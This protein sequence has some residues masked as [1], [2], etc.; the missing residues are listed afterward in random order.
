MVADRAGARVSSGVTPCCI[1]RH[2]LLLVLLL[3]AP[4]ALAAIPDLTN[5]GTRTEWGDINLGPTGMRGWMYHDNGDTTDSRQILVTSVEAGSPAAGI[6][7]ANDVILGVSGTGAAPTPFTADTCKTLGNAITNAEARNP[8]T[9]KFLRWRAG[10]TDTVQ[11][12]LQYFGAYSAT[13]PYNC[14]KSAAILEMGLQ[15]MMAT[16][17]CGQYSFGT[18]ALLAADDPS[19]PNNAARQ[20]RA[21]NEAIASIPNEGA[22]WS[23]S[24]PTVRPDW[25]KPWYAGHA[26]IVLCEYYLKTH[27]PAVLPG[28]NGFVHVIERGQSTFGSM[29]HFWAN[30]WPDGSPNGPMTGY[31]SVN[32]AAVPALLGLQ[33]AKKCGCTDPRLDI[34]IERASSFFASYVGKGVIPYG[35]HMP[36][37]SHSANGKSG[38]AAL[39]FEMQPQRTAARDYFAKIATAAASE[40]LGG[41]TGYW[42]NALWSPLGAAVGGEEAA[43]SHF[44]R[45]IWMFDLCRTWDGRFSYD[46]LPD[47]RAGYRSNWSGFNMSTAILLTYALPYRNLQI[48]GKGRA[49]AGCMSHEDVVKADLADIDYYDPTTRSTSQLIEDL[50]SFSCVVRPG[51][52]AELAGRTGERAQILAT[53]VSMVPNPNNPSRAGACDALARMGDPASASLLVAQLDDPDENVRYSATAALRWFSRDVLFP[54]I[55]EILAVAG[56][57]ARPSM[58]LD[59]ENPARL[60]D[61]ELASL[62]FQNILTDTSTLHSIDRNYLYPAIRMAALHP[63]GNVNRTMLSIYPMLSREDCLALA[64][65]LVDSVHHQSPGDRM[66]DRYVRKAGLDAMQSYNFAE[67]VPLAEMVVDPSDGIDVLRRYAGS[68]TLVEPDPRTIEFLIESYWWRSD[69]SW[70]ALDAINA[71]VADTNP[72]APT[73][74]KSIQSVT[75]DAPTLTLPANWTTLRVKAYDYAKGDSRFTWRKVHGKGEV[76]FAPNGTAGSKN[77]IALFDGTPGQYLFE[78]TMSDSRGFTEVRQTVAVTLRNSNGTLPSNSPPSALAQTLTVGTATPTPIT[79]TGSDPENLALNYQITTPPAHGALTGTA[80]YLVYTSDHNYTGSDTFTFQVMDSEGQVATANINLTVGTAAPTELAVYEPFDYPAGALNGKSGTSEVGFAGPW[81]ASTG[82]TISDG[83]LTYGPL[84]TKGGKAAGA[85]IGSRVISPSALADKGLLADGATLWMSAV[86]G[87]GPGIDRSYLCLFLANSSFSSAGSTWDQWQQWIQNEGAQ[88]GAGIGITLGYTNRDGSV[89]AAFVGN[90]ANCLWPDRFYFDHSG[91]IWDNI[92]TGGSRLVVAK[93]TWGATPQDDDRI[94]VYEPYTDLRLPDQPI[95]S[96][97]GKVD[98]STFD[99]LTFFGAATPVLD[100]IR[101]GADYRSVLMGSVPA[102]DAAAPVPNPIAFHSAPAPAGPTSIRMVASTAFDPSGVEYFFTCAAGGGHD[103]GWQ[104]SPEYT[105]TGLNPG[106]SYSYTVKA[107]D[108]SV[109]HNQTAPS[110]AA[111]ITLPVN[112]QVPVVLGFSQAEA[113]ALITSRGLVVGT[114]TTTAS[115]S[116]DQGDVAQ[117]NPVGGTSAALGAAVNLVVAE[118]VLLATVPNLTGQTQSAANTALAAQNLLVGTV[119][120]DYSET[121]PAGQI[122]STNPV[123]GSEINP[124]STVDLVVSAGSRS[125]LLPLSKLFFEDFESPTTPTAYAQG[126]LPDNGK[127][128]GSWVDYGSTWHGM[129]DKAGGDFSAP[130]PNYQAYALR[131]ANT[132]ITTA[133]GVVGTLTFNT[134]YTV[135]FDVVRDNFNAG[136]TYE[137]ELVAFNPGDDRRNATSKRPGTVLASTHGYAFSDGS[138]ARISFDFTALASSPHLGK[139]VA[140]RF[141]APWTQTNALIDNVSI[142]AVGV[143]LADTVPPLLVATSPQDEATGVDTHHVLTMTFNE[144]VT[145][146]AGGFTLR[147]VT[148]GTQQFLNPSDPSGVTCSG[149]TVRI[150]PSGGLLPNKQY[151]VFASIQAV[152]D[153]VGNRF[154]GITDASAWNFTT[155]DTDTTPPSLT[156]SNNCSTGSSQVG[157]AVTCLLAFSEEIKDTTLDATDLGNAGTSTISI[158]AITMVSPGFYSVSV[159]PTTTGTLQ[160][161]VN[162]GAVITDLAN[163]ALNTTT[164]IADAGT[165]T[166]VPVPTITYDG[167]GQTGG[168]APVSQEK[169]PNE[170][171]T[172]AN[173]YGSLVKTGYTFA[174]WNTAADGTGI[175]YPAGATYTID[176]PLTLYAYWELG[177]EG[178]WLPTT[179]GPFNWNDTANWSGGVVASGFNRTALFT[180]NLTANQTVNLDTA[181]TIGNITFTDSTTSSHDLTISGANLL[182]LSRTAGAPVI[183]VTQSGRWLTITTNITG[184]NGLQ[185]NGAGTLALSGTNNYTGP[186]TISAGTLQIYGSLTG[187]SGISMENGATLTIGRATFSQTTHLNGAVISGYGH[188]SSTGGGTATLSGANTYTGVT[189]VSGGTGGTLEVT[190][191]AN[192]GV[193]SSIGAASSN[194]YNLVIAGGNNTG[195]LRYIGATNATTDRLFTIG[196]Q[197]GQ[198][199]ILE[200]SGGGTVNF[201]NTGTVGYLTTNQVRILTLGGNNTGDNILNPQFVNNG[202]ATLSIVKTDVGTWILA[203]TSSSY[204]G[205]TTINSG[206]LGISKLTDYG[207]ASSIGKGTAGTAIAFN[208]GSLHY[209]GSGDSTNRVIQVS[210][211][212]GSIRNYGTAALNFTATGSFNVQGSTSTARTLTLGGPNGGTISGAIQNNT[213]TAPALSFAKSGMG[214]WTLQGNNTFT[215]TASANGGGNLVLDYTT[216]TGSKL[217]DTAALTLGGSAITLK[218]GT[219]ITETILSTTL[220]AGASRITRDGGTAVLQMNAITRQAGGNISFPDGTVATTDTANVNGILGGWATVGNDWAINSGSAD[221]PITALT[222]YTDTLPSTG[223][224]SATANYT[225]SG[226]QTQTGTSILNAFT[227]KLAGT[228]TADNT[229]ALAGTTLNITTTSATSLGGILYTGGGTDVYHITADAG[230]GINTSSTQD[231]II[232]TVT[233][234]LDVSAKINTGDSTRALLKAGAGTLVLG[235]PN[236]YTGTTRVNEGVLRLT[237]NTAPGT[238]AGGIVVQ[239]MA[240]LELSNSVVIGAEPLTLTGGGVSESGALRNLASNTSSYAGAITINGGGACIHSE[241]TGLLTL[242]GGIITSQYNDV[243][244]GGAG[245]IIVS[246][247]AVSGAGGL[248]KEGS[249]T[250]TLS[251][252]QTYTGPTHLAEGTV[253]LN[254]SLASKSISFAD[255]ATMVLDTGAPINAPNAVVDL[256]NATIQINGAVG[257]SSQ[258]ITAAAITGTPTLA[259]SMPGYGFQIVGTQLLLV[260]IPNY[261]PQWSVTPIAKAS[262]TEDAAYNASLANDARDVNNDS[263]TFAKV[264]GPAWLAVAPDGTLSGTPTNSDVGANSF[265][266]SVSDGTAPAVQATLNITVIN[267]NDVPVWSANPIIGPDANARTE[268]AATLGQSASDADAGTSLVFSL[269]DG[270]SWL[271]VAADGTLSGTPTQ[272]N[273]GLNVFTVSVGDGIAEPVNTTLNI[274]VISINE[275]PVF[276]ANPITRA[277]ATENI[278]YAGTLAGSATDV[279]DDPLTFTKISGPAWLAVASDGTLSG[280]PTHSDVGANSFTVSVSDGIAAPVT[281]ILNITVKNTNHAPTWSSNPVNGAAATEDAAYAG[282]LAGSATDV[283]AGDT[284]TFAKVSGPAWLSVATNGMLSGTP[285][286]SDVGS[287]SFTVSVSDGIAAPVQATLHITV[288]NTNDAPVFTI[289]PMSGADATQGTAYTGTLAGSASDVDNGATMTYAKVSGPAWLAVAPAGTLSGTPTHS[290]VGANSF[291][292]SVSDG[293]AAPVNATLNIQVNQVTYTVTYN[294][295]GHTGGTAPADQ[296]KVKDTDLILATN[297]GNLAKTGFTFAGWNSSADGSGTAYA[298]GATYTLNAPLTLFARWLR[299][300]DGTWLPT[301]AGPFNW[302]DTANWSGGGGATGS[303]R[304]ALFTPNITANQTVNLDTAT[305]IGNITFTDST[306]SS[307]DLTISGANLLTLSRT[308]SAPVIDVTQSGR[309]L[310]I[311]T[312]ITGTNGLQKNGLGNLILSGTNTYTGATTVQQGTLSINSIASYGAD[313]AIGKGTLGTAILLGNISTT[314]TLEYTGGVQSTNRTI[315]I[316][317]TASTDT[318]GATILNNG[319]GALTFAA[320][321]FNAAYTNG[322]TVTRTLTLGGSNGGTISGTIQNNSATN[323]VALTKIDSGTWTLTGVNT[324]S[325]KTTVSSG[326]LAVTGG[327]KLYS[328]LNNDSANLITINSGGTIEFDNWLYGTSGGSFGTLWYANTNFVINGGKL[329]YVGTTANGSANRSFTIGASGATLESATSG[330]KWTVTSG[331]GYTTLASNGGTLTLTGAG[332]GQIDQTIPGTGGLTKSGN[333]TWTLAG[334][335]TYTGATAVQQGNLVAGTNAP[336][337]VNGAFGHATSDINLGVAG[338]NSDA[339]LLIGGAFTVGRNIRLLTSN[340]TDGGTRVLTIGGNTAANSEF[341]GSIFL[342]ATNFAGRGVTLT[343]ASGGQVTFSG[344]IQNPTSMDATSYTVNKAGAGTVVLSNSN[345]YTGATAITEGTLKLGANDVLP[346]GSAVSIGTATLDADTR[347][348]TVGT[349]NVTGSAVINLGSGAALTFADSSTVGSGT[350]AGTLNLIGFVSGSSLNFGSATGLTAAQ[351]SKISATGFSNFKLDAGG[352]LIATIQTQYEAWAGGAGFGADANGDGV[353]NGL[354]WLLGASGPNAA[355]TLPTTSQTGANLVMRFTCLA[356]ADR[357]TATLTLEYK[358]DLVGTWLSV[359]VPGAVGAPNPVVETTTTGSVSFVATDGGTNGNGDAL[360]HVVATISDATE[361]ASG[362]LFGRVKGTNP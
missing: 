116:V 66:N 216:N 135:S 125:T 72:V 229:L 217:P 105:D 98:Q 59:P 178:T 114:I 288:I 188:V 30:D 132:G 249:G 271:Q 63:F 100:E 304:T 154:A 54:L 207:T 238:I 156:L 143:P 26:L 194:P 236:A 185:K 209:I 346:N 246:T 206:I 67:G 273:V 258:L 284:L 311:S 220:S 136:T 29:G 315:Q 184:T 219:S 215:G 336:S 352:K 168:I 158:G 199:C 57:H 293:I 170:D 233:G 319:S 107:R 301:T 45:A 334:T 61:A 239:N 137:C 81:S 35:E 94:E 164:A 179:A 266:V 316:N 103:S 323:S 144:P 96:Q 270:P 309:T 332:D 133:Q 286:N 89:A 157:D 123:A 39:V 347:T 83:S 34:G 166:I 148:D 201:T 189:T 227:L 21:R 33:L 268:Y 28:I 140:V 20:T 152:E 190:S 115:S 298:V 138:F 150:Y 24:S 237:N 255:G 205:S 327:G 78:V 32:S 252:P 177:T 8:A 317:S 118:T 70:N 254:G 340:T 333:G 2:W 324:Y 250:L 95:A 337:G 15:K 331:S 142:W 110:T 204:T 106:G 128:L 218:G 295:N 62:L 280:T 44:R 221:G 278:A 303:N 161:K 109:A 64:D 56:K 151:T 297:S 99:T 93:I 5:G 245:D 292:V 299:D 251:G 73:P 171:L 7:A 265:T 353:S 320:A 277:N 342:G 17:S 354:A 263:L 181:T 113:E 197:G 344:V 23:M 176:A 124:G 48:T 359:P 68:C 232:N 10:V 3:C 104:S 147:N 269:S 338:G 322:S 191:L 244:F 174:G 120:T 281:A 126:W 183:D 349:L 85:K 69:S 274:T 130:H 187:T 60:A 42:F 212:N 226:G 40:R 357:G 235:G 318:G 262:A 41:H 1:V 87:N 195:V 186:T 111:S 343:A 6:L 163:N 27:D 356:T 330:Q 9:L 121:V 200:S 253:V 79:L 55:Y 300:T 222:S 159:T 167:N 257:S 314:G 345:T 169:Q 341:S 285:I 14:P 291:T 260:E 51:A 361:S 305:T 86:V 306:T 53:L 240:A 74:F 101:F 335:N 75:A 18:L 193:A 155:T 279:N 90:A 230:K 47:N 339:G 350:W 261:A 287:N 22:L 13:A 88:P 225:L 38:A 129:T 173:N 351:L 122:I 241:T 321:T 313:S 312:N 182:T 102:T 308:A 16:E 4:A 52:S 234:T 272:A 49:P 127:W 76:L 46:K 149:N 82:N 12:T 326:T 283:D 131:Y 108:C 117:Q 160:L 165:L 25:P 198:A 267:T 180:P 196:N 119:F 175:T 211:G 192:A 329:R 37:G 134:R 77:T 97:T 214:T 302:N 290:D 11:I 58:P 247:T 231:L 80:P 31:G 294:G 208:G 358:G 162:A 242:T 248:V 228:G 256:T 146:G 112:G 145:L 92:P 203:N 307:H 50:G 213:G 172:L 210:G 325:G 141:I 276:T 348:D 43:A 36:G 243:T 202:T 282:T 275:A 84:L 259:G 310:T 65:V 223:T 91:N 71:I 19:N 224:G 296:V 153:Q 289:N 328:T 355:V 360:I 139:D 362:K 264:S